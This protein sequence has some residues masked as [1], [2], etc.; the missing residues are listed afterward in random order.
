MSHSF[1][2]DVGLK[3]NIFDD[4][5]LL[6]ETITAGVAGK[7][8]ESVVKTLPTQ[9]AIICS[10]LGTTSGNLHRLYKR[11]ALDKHQSEEMLDILS[12]F[13]A[14]F[15]LYEDRELAQELLNT[16]LPALNN[17]K[18]SELLDTFTGRR[19]VKET[20]NKMAWGEFS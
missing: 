12:V 15:S 16:P 18:P 17:K 4:Q 5:Y 14:A 8:V 2:T 13:N 9:R 19:M 20:L 3:N 11:K 10:A 7:V 6:L 1:I